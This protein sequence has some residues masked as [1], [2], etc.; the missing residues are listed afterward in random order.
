VP[1]IEP[2]GSVFQLVANPTGVHLDLTNYGAVTFV[3]S[4]TNGDQSITL[5][6][7]KAGASE[8]ALSVIDTVYKCPRTGGDW[9]KVTQTASDSFTNADAT[10]NQISVT[11]HAESLDTEY[12]AVEATLTNTLAVVAI[13]WNPA[14]PKDPSKLAA[15]NVT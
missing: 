9:L 5:K 14:Y 11:V 1:T 13:M 7:S 2:I 4:A 15:V 10:N 3:C 12:T 8:I 6:Q